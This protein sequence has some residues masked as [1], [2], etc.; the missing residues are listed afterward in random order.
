MWKWKIVDLLPQN[1]SKL[2]CLWSVTNLS[3]GFNFCLN[4]WGKQTI[5]QL[6]FLPLQKW[7][8]SNYLLIGLFKSI[9]NK[10]V[11][12]ATADSKLCLDGKSHQWKKIFMKILIGLNYLLANYC[13]TAFNVN[14]YKFQTVSNIRFY[15]KLFECNIFWNHVSGS[16]PL[17]GCQ[18]DWRW[19]NLFHNANSLFQNSMER[20]QYN[21]RKGNEVF[22]S[23]Y[24]PDELEDL[25]SHKLYKKC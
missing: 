11:I 15:L 2:F 16:N 10:H 19:K 7:K 8:W 17:G 3:A 14:K 22:L 23:G 4:T 24:G 25:I 5:S 6:F 9:S 1:Y 20:V 13:L 12:T 18:S 21:H